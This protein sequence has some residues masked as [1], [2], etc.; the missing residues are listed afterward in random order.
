MSGVEN[1]GRILMNLRTHVPLPLSPSASHKLSFL[2]KNIQRRLL[3]CCLPACLPASPPRMPKDC[4]R[5]ILS[6]CFVLA[7]SAQ[8]FGLL[9]HK[10]SN[11]NNCALAALLCGEIAGIKEKDLAR[12]VAVCQFAA[13]QSICFPRLP[14]CAA[15]FSLSPTPTT[16][17]YIFPCHFPA[18]LLKICFPFCSIFR[19]PSERS[20]KGCCGQWFAGPPLRALIAVVALGGVACALGGA[21]LGATGLAGPPNSHLTAALLMIGE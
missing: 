15:H 13:Q 14:T 1:A 8:I 6:A 7:G 9:P 11:Y 19:S 16:F 10:S 5:R 18:A 17:S 2:G 21:A 4:L 20:G 12:D 3:V